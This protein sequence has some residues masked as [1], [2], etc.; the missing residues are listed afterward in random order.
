MGIV[1]KVKIDSDRCKGCTLC[2]LFCPGK[3]LQI[4][5]KFNKA[6]YHPAVF[7]EEG[8]CSGCGFC[9]L[10]CPDVCIEVEK[11]KK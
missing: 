11:D 2:V 9:Y 1:S 7:V 10:M 3:S 6:G 5:K 4:S 8:K